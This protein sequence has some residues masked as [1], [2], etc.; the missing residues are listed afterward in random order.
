MFPF[1]AHEQIARV[2]H[3]ARVVL[4]SRDLP[5]GR[6]KPDDACRGMLI[7]GIA[8]TQLTKV[9]P[10]KRECCAVFGNHYSV[11]SSCRYCHF[12]HV[13]GTICLYIILFVLS[14]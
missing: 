12:V 10:T 14:M 7:V 5:H 1:T 6:K 13:L 4:P 8:D 11:L 2:C 9:I 3:D